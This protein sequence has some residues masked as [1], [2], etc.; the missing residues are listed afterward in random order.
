MRKFLLA[1]IGAATLLTTT[2]ALP[3][4]ATLADP[5]RP[6]RVSAAKSLPDGWR[7]EGSD[8]RTLTWVAKRPVPMTDAAVKFFANGRSL[9]AAAE[10]EDRRTFRVHLS[11][12]ADVHDLS[13]D[14]SGRRLDAPPLPFAGPTGQASSA[15]AARLPAESAVDPGKAG[16][17]ETLSGEYTLPD[18]TLPGLPAKVEMKALVVGPKAAK[19]PLPMVLLLHGRHGT[20]YYGPA[21]TDLAG[22]WPCPGTAKPV[23][24]YRGYLQSQRLL[25]SQGYLT[26][27]I[28]ANGINAQDGS[29]ADGGAEMRSSLIRMHLAHWAEWAADRSG[30]PDVV[31]DLPAAD[32][33]RLLLMGHSRGG[34]GANMAAVDS[35]NPPP[36]TVAGYHGPAGWTIR[37]TVLFGP[38]AYGQNPAPDVPSLTVLPGCDGDVS[39]LEGQLYADATRGVSR[40]AALH[41]VAYVVGANHN[42][43]NTEWTPT[44]SEAPSVDDADTTMP[45]CGS[46]AAS[47]RLTAPQESAVGATYLAAAAQLFLAGDDRVRPLLDGTGERAPSVD[48]A[49]VLT[50][51]VGADRRPLVLPE[52]DTVVTG[53]GR[54]CEET[55]ITAAT[56]CLTSASQSSPHFAAFSAPEPERVAVS[57]TMSPAATPVTVRP[58]TISSLA[59]SASV[60]LRVIVPPVSTG[61]NFT[62]A[63]TDSAGHR[64][65]L[66]TAKV[67]GIPATRTALWGQEIRLPLPAAGVANLDLKHIASL[68]IAAQGTEGT[69]Y[70]IDAWGWRP[71]TPAP[72]TAPLLRVDLGKLTVNEGDSG[73]QSYTVPITYTGKGSGTIRLFSN[74]ITTANSGTDDTDKTDFKVTEQ[75]ITV[76]PGSSTTGP[77]STIVGN[78]LYGNDQYES[79]FSKAVKGAT[80]GQF[81]G[82][83]IVLDDDPQ[84][85]VSVAPIA[86]KVTAGEPL[87]YRVSLSTLAAAP[88]FVQFIPQVPTPGPELRI[89]DVDPVW[90]A[91]QIGSESVNPATPLSSTNL[92]I[93]ATIPAGKL[94]IDVQI[95][96]RKNDGVQPAKYFQAQL[97]VLPRVGSKINL[98]QTIT[99][100][101]AAG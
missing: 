4:N 48:P 61:N 59:D 12:T 17:Y 92:R 53:A 94:S 64:A 15:T 13:V 97:G 93:S 80:V 42:F 78:T 41:A 86:D 49:Q 63:L 52:V 66:G 46:G 62:V 21:E 31:R 77:K 38:T 70:L 1:V 32:L 71:G 76:Q 85:T 33:S 98:G 27:S 43:F 99:G 96:T 90:Y 2:I 20:C 28:S 24:S 47:K 88:V 3:A 58:K 18:V 100:S 67:D 68:E 60:A 83:L 40:G 25:A 74:G 101:I 6:N 81:S 84:P 14:A 45:T 89:S 50:A 36:D 44:L 37:G 54:I 65:V 10:S 26:V 16:V 69:A 82:G 51:A 87:T 57:L 56:S 75:T 7:W 8:R 79:M 72:R 19:G 55:G 91:E 35:V 34:E 73:T 5:P 95:P 22:G 30:A 23:P 29:L 39:N 11:P 9:G